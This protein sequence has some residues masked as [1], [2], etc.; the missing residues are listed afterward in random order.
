MK[1]NK[2]ITLIA[3]VVTIIVLLILAGVAIAMLTGDNSILKRAQSTQAYSAIGAA[4]DEVNLA[5]NA[6]FA[7]YL[8]T[9]YEST[10]STA[11]TKGFGNY[12]AEQLA[13]ATTRTTNRNTSN[14][15]TTIKVGGAAPSASTAITDGQ[16]VEI[17]YKDNQT[18]KTFTTKATITTSA[19]NEKLSAWSAVVEN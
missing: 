3:L 8:K 17:Q 18:S 16:E 12:M 2:G 6:A 14:G 15:T 11:V 5:Y 13:A 1:G 4:K 10:N 7:E 19:E 9:K